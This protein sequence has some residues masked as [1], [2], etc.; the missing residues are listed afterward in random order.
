[1][2]KTNDL[3]IGDYLI[4]DKKR[5]K[6]TA[7]DLDLDG[8]SDEIVADSNY[9]FIELKSGRVNG[10][11]LTEEVLAEFGFTKEGKLSDKLDKW[12][13]GH[14]KFILYFNGKHAGLITT[15]PTTVP[16]TYLH[17]LQNLYYTLTGLELTS[18]KEKE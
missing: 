12:V 18:N 4:F 5:S 16:C 9:R 1:M 17:Q 3:R 8:V 6:I 15:L 7:I 11:Q 14:S 2:I 10:I 13:A